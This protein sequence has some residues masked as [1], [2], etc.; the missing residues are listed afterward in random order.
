MSLSDRAAPLEQLFLAWKAPTTDFLHRLHLL[1]THC[2]LND[3]AGL[4]GPIWEDFRVGSSADGDVCSTL[5][6]GYTLT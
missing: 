6:S 1:Y 5:G 4:T 3:R 2:L